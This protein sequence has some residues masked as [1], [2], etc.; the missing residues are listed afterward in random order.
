MDT[1]AE[2]VS[3]PWALH[4]WL[5]LMMVSRSW[6][7]H[8]GPKAFTVSYSGPSTTGRSGEKSLIVRPQ[9]MGQPRQA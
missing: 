5:A 2:M 3:N 4:R 8:R 7:R 9:P 1:P 6:F